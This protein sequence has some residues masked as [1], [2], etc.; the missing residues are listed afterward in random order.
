MQY[1]PAG[2]LWTLT[3][4]RLP[5]V[6]D[7]RSRSVFWSAFFAATASTLYCPDV[8]GTVDTLLG[9]RNVA[10]LA[11]LISLMLGFWQF[12]SA[13]LIAVTPDETRRRRQLAMGRYLVLA[14]GAAV[15]IGFLLSNPGPT[16]RNLQWAYAEQPGM[17][18]FLWA[19][20]AFL[21]WAG[22]D[23]AIVCIRA[24]DRFQSSAFRVGFFMVSLGCISS[25]LAI[26]DR[27]VYGS[28]NRNQLPL[29]PFASVLDSTYWMG[30]G[31][32]V[33]FLGIGLIIPALKKPARNL[34][35]S[36]EARLLLIRLRPAWLHATE[37]RRDLVLAPSRLEFLTPLKPHADRHL[38]RRLIEIRDCEM[39][40]GKI[41]A[42]TPTGPD[43]LDRAETL[44][45]RS[46]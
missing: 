36:L 41:A 7:A 43:W 8:Y 22:L 29:T 4:L 37:S 38:H 5:H 12:R 9:G 14:S 23:L 20:S 24:L 45:N 40:S 3:L 1:I 42:P 39:A 16:N 10:K 21:F 35:Q 2:I 26:A 28:I 44:L 31:L 11:T 18:V 6:R 30:E 25:C 46:S 33:T 27:V 32:A 19:G 17:T 34:R 13:I 15:V